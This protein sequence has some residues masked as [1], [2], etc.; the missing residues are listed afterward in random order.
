[1]ANNEIRN[2]RLLNNTITGSSIHR[3]YG[4]YDETENVGSGQTRFYRH[5][6]YETNTAIT[7]VLRDDMS[8]AP[9][10]ST[11]WDEVKNIIYSIRPSSAQAFIGTRVSV[12]LDTEF[13]SSDFAHLT[14][15]E[16]IIDKDG[17]Y[18]VSVTSS[19]G[20]YSG[21]S[22]SGSRTYLQVDNGSGFTDA[23]LL[24]SQ[25]HRGYGISDDTGS[26]TILLKLGA[27]FKLR[28][29]T[30]RY[31]G[32]ATLNTIPDGYSLNMWTSSG[33]K[34]E[35]GADGDI[36]WEGAWTV[37]NYTSNQAVEY[38]GSAY[39]CH[40]DTTS[41]QNPLD[42]NF[43][44]ILASKGDTGDQGIQGATGAD[45]DMTWEG[46]WSAGTYNENQCVERNGS[47]YV[48]TTN[49]TI[50]QPPGTGWDTLAERGL[51]GSGTSLNIQEEGTSVPNTPHSTLNFVGERITAKDSGSGVATVTIKEP[52]LVRYGKSNTQN[53]TATET[54]LAF[55]TNIK[56]DT[57][58][59]VLDTTTN[60]GRITAQKNIKVLID[61]NVD[62]LLDTDDT[63]RN[64][65]VCY[66]KVNGTRIDYTTAA[67]YT[68][69]YN[70]DK[71]G[72]AN[73]CGI[74]LELNTNDYI[75]VFVIRDDDFQSPVLGN[76]ETW[77]TIKE[78]F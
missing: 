16:V 66:I 46:T 3:G 17:I 54:L 32:T 42:T 18:F 50:T 15:G 23:T 62:M 56:T 64:T 55:E 28:I 71:H 37:Q 29:Q 49:G 21:T 26:Q 60:I 51:D 13:D 68:R 57:T 65:V 40:T 52:A 31:D 14:L 39:V 43:W 10:I 73:A 75:E 69:G 61:Y 20:T 63:Q 77:I 6:F 67:S 44:D 53:L 12:D 19:N 24:I 47:S 72:V 38:L 78:V 27:G 11:D 70:Y 48:C 76:A 41:S 8:N 9:D 25:Y 34:G 22:R 58:A 45:G 4:F 74:Y 5:S 36:A 1:M 7:G 2:S 30:V 35:K 59:F 33:S